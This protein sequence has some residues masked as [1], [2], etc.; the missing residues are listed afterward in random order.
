V[1]A[2]PVVSS[3]LVEATPIDGEIITEGKTAAA[4][5]GRH[6]ALLF[7][8]VAIV[9]IAVAIGVGVGVASPR[10]SEAPPLSTNA[11]VVNSTNDTAKTCDDD[12]TAVS[13]CFNE[14]IPA[15]D[16]QEVCAGCLLAEQRKA[17]AAF[18]GALQGAPADCSSISD[19][20][21][22]PLVNCTCAT[23]C[24]TEVVTYFQCQL[25]ATFAQYDLD[26]V[27]CNITCAGGPAAPG[28]SP[29]ASIA[30][31]TRRGARSL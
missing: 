29:P 2:E 22:A 16:E 27:S 18:A 12:V 31:T 21:C 26:V 5:R 9:A 15:D 23:P 10:R 17:L 25:A 4:T 8:A 19:L 28:S 7:A 30:P 3:V 24:S 11:T 1:E 20:V 14:T 13:A 6:C